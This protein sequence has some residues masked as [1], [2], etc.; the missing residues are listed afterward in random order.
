MGSWSVYCGISK[1]V[2]TSGQKCVLLPLKKNLNGESYLSYL[3][4]TLPIFGEYDDYGGIENIEK[5]D[6]TKLIEEHFGVSIEDFSFFFTRGIV[7][8]DESDFPKK[9]KKVEEIKKWTFMFIDRQVY[10]FMSEYV[11]AG[12]GGGGGLDYGNKD[13]LNLLGFNYIGENTNKKVYDYQRFNK[14]WELN[15]EKFYSDGTWL[16]HP[17]GSVHTLNG[18]YSALS[19]YV[20]IPEDKLWVG[21]KIM[22]QLWEH[23]SDV[24]A[25]KQ[26]LHIIGKRYSSIYDDDEMDTSYLPEAFQKLKDWEEKNKDLDISQEEKNKVFQKIIV[27][28]KNGVKK[29][30]K[31]KTIVDAYVNDFRKYAKLLCDLVTI[32]HNLYPM[33]GTFEPYILYLTPQCGEHKHH[34]VLLN[35]FAEINA[36]NISE[37]GYDEEDDE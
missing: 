3:P 17:K 4:A 12:F 34:Q 6:N 36:N 31:P 23:L 19:E 33:S 29:I 8:D 26:L 10:D 21:Q 30:E 25:K 9:L 13:I 18:K 5:D 28:A 32:R 35:K 37:L 14:E 1:I 15:G 11:H 22:W 2:I 20:K 7:R 27:E 16:C 24:N